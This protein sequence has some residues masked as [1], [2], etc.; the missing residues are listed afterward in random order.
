MR[1]GCVFICALRLGVFVC[2]LQLPCGEPAAAGG[3]VSSPRAI[4]RTHSAPARVFPSRDHRAASRLASLCLA[5]PTLVPR[6]GRKL[7][8]TRR[9]RLMLRGSS[10]SKPAPCGR[11]REA[12]SQGARKEGGNCSSLAHNSQSCVMNSSSASESSFRSSLGDRLRLRRSRR[13]AISRRRSSAWASAS[14]CLA[15][16]PE[17]FVFVM[18]RC[19]STAFS[20]A[21]TICDSARDARSRSCDVKPF[22]FSS[23]VSSPSIVL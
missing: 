22:C 14:F 12:K 17:D 7:P 16:P 5:L 2:P 8:S 23:L 9:A 3:S 1:A 10:F 15:S 4:L 6:A 21:L 20:N 13:S 18:S 19:I 11:L